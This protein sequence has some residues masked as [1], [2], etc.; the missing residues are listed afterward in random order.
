M[1]KDSQG[2][3]LTKGDTGSIFALL[4]S[5]GKGLCHLRVPS[6]ELLAPAHQTVQQ[7]RFV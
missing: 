3:V 1:N 7:V 4:D 2:W 5:I 6:L